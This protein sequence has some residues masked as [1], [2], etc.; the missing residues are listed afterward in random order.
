MARLAC[1][2]GTLEAWWLQKGAFLG[3]IQQLPTRKLGRGHTRCQAGRQTER[4]TGRQMGERGREEGGRERRGKGRRKKAE[5]GGE[6]KTEKDKTRVG[7]TY[8]CV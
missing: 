8:H 2:L 4:Q 3:T 6:R 5:K 7:K 1:D